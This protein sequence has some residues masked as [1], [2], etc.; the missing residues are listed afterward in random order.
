MR[1]A[2][3]MVSDVIGIPRVQEVA[4]TRIADWIQY[5]LRI[6]PEFSNLCFIVGKGNNGANAVSAARILHNRGWKSISVVLACSESEH[7]EF[8]KEHLRIFKLFGGTIVDSIPSFDWFSPR[9][10]AVTIVDGLLGTGVTRNPS[11]SIATWIRKINELN[12]PVLALDVPSGLHHGSGEILDP[13][14][15]AYST[16][17]FHV[18]KSGLMATQAKLNVGAVW[19]ADTDLS[20]D[21]FGVEV[22]TS[23][24]HIYRQ[25]PIVHVSLGPYENLSNLAKT[26]SVL[27]EL[28]LFLRLFLPDIQSGISGDEFCF[29][30]FKRIQNRPLLKRYLQISKLRV[31]FAL[32]LVDMELRDFQ[33]G[34]PCVERLDLFYISSARRVKLNELFWI[35]R[36]ICRVASVPSFFDFKS[37]MERMLQCNVAVVSELCSSLK[38]SD[39][40]F[41][42]LHELI[43][44]PTKH[45]P[46][47][48]WLLPFEINFEANYAEKFIRFPDHY[49][50][51]RQH[52]FVGL[53]WYQDHRMGMELP[54]TAES[55]TDE[56]FGRLCC[57]HFAE[58]LK[59]C[60]HEIIHCLQQI[61]NQHDSSSISWSAE[62]D[63]SFVEQSLFYQ[64]ATHADLKDLF[65]PGFREL[66]LIFE[67]ER[68][69]HCFSMLPPLERKEYVKWRNSFGICCPELGI[70]DNAETVDHFKSFIASE[71]VR[72][73]RI[74]LENQLKKLFKNRSGNVLRQ[75][76]HETRELE[77][78]TEYSLES[79]VE[80][81]FSP[82]LYTPTGCHSYFSA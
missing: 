51:T 71:S 29:L 38:S 73:D 34:T 25:A 3:L 28:L 14:T 78:E 4:S 18:L 52:H 48:P 23:L 31:N 74:S 16:F 22:S 82:S 59:V 36:E 2:D 68:T 33:Y 66:L 7:N 42:C 70:E 35:I 69:A 67:H 12:L 15:R 24:R 50:L 46:S 55:L 64:V 56:M 75:A 5:V 32:D 40:L 81:S 13:C 44:I 54:K 10:P 9:S 6:D 65:P 49:L 53:K 57:Y 79:F 62:H 43:P 26:P 1:A 37:I 41:Q 77:I 19:T 39:D 17:C 30:E 58:C 80:A 20:F 45:D 11:G 63:A 60:S 47:N 76:V 8:L 61:F 27:V 21:V 72:L